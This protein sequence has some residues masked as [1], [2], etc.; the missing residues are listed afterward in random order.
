[1]T[2]SLPRIFQAFRP[3]DESLDPRAKARVQ[4]YRLLSLL[5]AV[6]FPAVGLL[7]EASSLEAVDPIGHRLVISGL[8]TGLFGASYISEKVRRHYVG[9]AWG[10]LYLTMAWVTVLTALN[11]FSGEYAVVFLLTYVLFGGIIALGSE[12]LEPVLWFLSTGF[13]LV[14]VGFWGAS[15]LRTSPLI[16]TVTMTL[17]AL[18]GSV[19]AWWGLSMRSRLASQTR[20]FRRQ[21]HLLEQAQR[22]TGAWMVNLRTNE[23]SWS[24]EGYRIHEL[25]P[26]VELSLETALQFPHPEAR[27]KVRR[28]FERCVEE[29]EPYDLEHPIVTAEGN[30]RWVRTVGGPI[31]EESGEIVKVAGAFQDLTERKRAE[32]ALKRER[33]RL[34]HHRDLLRRTQEIA[35]V[36]GWEYDLSTDTVEGTDQLNQII[37]LPEGEDVTLERS[38]QFFPSDG[39]DTVRKK[40]RRC[41]E[42]GDP[43]DLEVPLIREDGQRRWARVRG[44]RQQRE[45]GSVRLTGTL[46]DVT[47]QKEVERVLREEQEVLREMY[48]ITADRDTAFD[49]KVRKLIDLGRSYLGLSYGYLTRI[50]EGTQEITHARGEHPTLRP[51]ER[52]P[53]SKSYCRNTVEEGLLAIQNAP[54]EGWRGDPV[55]ET[56]GVDAYIGSKV[57]VGGNLHGTFCFAAEAPRETPFSERERTF[58]ELLTLWA[59]YEI[60]RHRATRQLE[61]Q[62]QRLDRFASVVSHD[63]RNP[64]NVATGR[65][66]LAEE[67]LSISTD[68]DT[69]ASDTQVSESDADRSSSDPR[70]GT[71]RRAHG[72]G[73]AHRRGA[74]LAGPYER[75]HR[76][77]AHPDV[78]PPRGRRGRG[79]ARGL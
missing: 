68:P 16:L 65:L 31:E 15:P 61:K 34:R 63:L 24:E 26:D 69:Q 42:Q 79:R 20:E 48:H 55:S 46:Q 25:D 4:I 28:A 77:H 8:L 6:L 1:M 72:G 35:K 59:G 41:I 70:G 51:G 75:A 49:A 40:V 13:L 27:P 33:E 22:L 37:G 19:C 32:Q 45:D 56:F 39:R 3:E 36:G 50:S 73:R 62:N 52:F 54:E 78:E 53:L 17:V 38:F 5:G 2:T 60:D 44:Q 12:S 23:L 57:E 58:V 29:G 67:A 47:E 76:R 14:G 43:F 10:L 74:A 66:Q 64:L 30:R 18:F 21:K 9:L 71:G 7:F 11:Q